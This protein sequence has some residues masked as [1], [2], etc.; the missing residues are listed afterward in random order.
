MLLSALNTGQTVGTFLPAHRLPSTLSPGPVARAYFA[1]YQARL[2]KLV[3]ALT[4]VADNTLSL[5][6]TV[7]S[8]Q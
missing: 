3:A 2:R 1:S 6:K 8:H 5:V 7:L 4:V